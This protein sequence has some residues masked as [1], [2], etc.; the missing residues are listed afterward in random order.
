MGSITTVFFGGGNGA[1]GLYLSKNI[2]FEL[3]GEGGNY[4]LGAAAGFN[5][6]LVGFRLQIFF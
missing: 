4:A 2:L 1:L 5:Y 6:Y 3:N